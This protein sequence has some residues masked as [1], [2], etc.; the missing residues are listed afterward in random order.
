LINDVDSPLRARSPSFL[1]YAC[2]RALSSSRYRA[3]SAAAAGTICSAAAWLPR[4]KVA[5]AVSLL[6]RTTGQEADF[7][8]TCWHYK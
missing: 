6:H 2:V 5:Y 7:T 1:E 3:P 8:A 4:W